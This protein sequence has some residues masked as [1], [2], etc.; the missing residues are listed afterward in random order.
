[1]N[2]TICLYSAQLHL[3]GGIEN[4]V[5]DLYRILPPG[6]IRVVA[7]CEE[8]RPDWIRDADY[9]LLPREGERRAAA[10]REFLSL[11]GVS[12][13]VFNHVSGDRLR[14]VREDIGRLRAEG[15][16]CVKM[17]HSPFLAPWLVDGEELDNRAIA[18]LADACDMTFTVSR[19]DALWWAALGHKAVKIQNPIHPPSAAASPRPPRHAAADAPLEVLWAGRFSPQKKP[20][21]ALSVLAR[22]RAKGANVHLT[23][24][25]GGAG[26]VRAA[27]RLARRLGIADAVTFLTA[28][29]GI[30]DLWQKADAHLLTSTTESFCLVL[31]EA[32][33]TGIPTVMFDIPTIE[34]TASRK[35]LVVAPQGD[36]EAL[37]DGL[38]RLAAD[39]GFCARLGAEAKE[40]LAGFDDAHVLA[41]WQA[42]LRALETG[43]GG[44]AVS[45]D[46]RLFA[47]QVSFGW[48]R[49]CNGHLWLVDMEEDAARL[50]L[51]F[52]PV[53]RLLAGFTRLVRRVKEWRK[54]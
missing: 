22:A 26:Q 27:R 44:V 18:F 53:A 30:A 13:V 43:E 31:A 12:C 10:W 5:R 9:L 6:G 14:T 45:D 40:S 20:E 11:N 21:A 41:D 19:A 17:S 1:M 48:D 25:G 46:A 38:A 39:R 51:S 23:M 42:A 3:T 8:G 52:R 47:T 4:V 7:A 34:L 15:V 37:A 29:P 54:T 49:Y 50:R 28:R 36:V 2:K 32:K 33:A 24:V 35:G 16:K